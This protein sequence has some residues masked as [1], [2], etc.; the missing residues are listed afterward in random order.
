MANVEYSRRICY[1]PGTMTYAKTFSKTKIYFKLKL[2]YAKCS[3]LLVFLI[4]HT[5]VYIISSYNFMKI[6]ECNIYS[7]RIFLFYLYTLPDFFLLTN[8]YYWFSFL[9]IRNCFALNISV[10]HWFKL[11]AFNWFIKINTYYPSLTV[12]FVAPAQHFCS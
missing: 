3:S 7:T 11:T 5:A 10:Q 1:D 2:S 6:F 12:T 9:R 4:Q 8:V